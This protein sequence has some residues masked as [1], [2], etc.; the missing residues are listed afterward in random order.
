MFF[1]EII[2]SIHLFLFCQHWFE[3]TNVDKIKTDTEELI[4]FY[5]TTLAYEMESHNAFRRRE[6]HAVMLDF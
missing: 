1:F 2:L 3:Q 4:I 6:P 5:V